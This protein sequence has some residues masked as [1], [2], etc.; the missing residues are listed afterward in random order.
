MNLSRRAFVGSLGAVAACR[1]IRETPLLKIALCSD[2]HIKDAETAENMR[3]VFEYAKRNDVDGV[4]IAGDITSDGREGQMKLF[5]DA[6]FSVFPDSRN[7]RGEKVELISCYGNRDLDRKH[8]PNDGES[9]IIRTAPGAMWRKY[10]GETV[11]DDC[12]VRYVKGCPVIL[13]HWGYEKI[14]E[15]QWKKLIG[16]IDTTKPFFYIQHPHLPGTVFD[17]EVASKGTVSNFLSNCPGAIAFSGHSH[18]SISDERAVWSGGFVSIAGGAV[19]VVRPF[20]GKRLYENIGRLGARRNQPMPR[21]PHMP[22][23]A[24]IDGISQA[25]ILSLYHDR[26]EIERHD[27][28]IDEKAGPVWVIAHPQKC[29]SQPRFGTVLSPVAPQ[30]P[31]GSKLELFERDGANRNGEKERQIVVSF[32]PAVPSDSVHDRVWDYEVCALDAASTVIARQYVLAENYFAPFRRI[33]GRVEC[34]FGSSS[35]PQGV[36]TRWKVVP[37]GFFGLCGDSISAVAKYGIMNAN[38][39]S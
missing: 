7:A 16:G 24:D 15:E 32:P 8:S 19:S 2:P 26:I 13:V 11:G 17:G 35:V 18:R 34:V 14:P 31:A 10:F 20:A 33:S 36:A 9:G 21:I 22:E 39:S 5:A 3:R 25:M 6:W 38:I 37:Y 30:F 4:L 23:T 1:R 28:G 12:H 27:C 29:G